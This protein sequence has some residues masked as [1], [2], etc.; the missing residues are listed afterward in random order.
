MWAESPVK[1]G[2][3][4]LDKIVKNQEGE[5]GGKSR[6]KRT[7][8]DKRDPAESDRGE[9]PRDRG[10]DNRRGIKNKSGDRIKGDRGKCGRK[11][12]LSPP[13]KNP[14]RNKKGEGKT[15]KW[16]PLSLTLG[17]PRESPIPKVE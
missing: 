13:K 12:V 2:I 7:R 8:K 9:E 14:K 15:K 5:R 6:G 16:V 3:E 11:R 17:P 10:K 4:A 1:G